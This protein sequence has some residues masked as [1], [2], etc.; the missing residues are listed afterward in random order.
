MAVCGSQVL[1]VKGIVTYKQGK[2]SRMTLVVMCWR[3]QYAL[4]FRTV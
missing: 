4:M 2:T 1:T 3:H